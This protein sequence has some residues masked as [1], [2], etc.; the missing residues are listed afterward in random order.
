MDDLPD[1]AL[2]SF[3]EP[4][5]DEEVSPAFLAVSTLFA[6][7]TV[8]FTIKSWCGGAKADP[9][10][11]KPKRDPAC[12]LAVYPD[13]S[14]RK[15]EKQWKQQLS[16]EV[17]LSLRKAEADMPNLTAEEGG[18]EHF[19]EDGIFRCA[20]CGTPVYDNDARF[21][22]GCGWPC[23]YTCLPRA[24]RERRDVDGSRWEL[25]CNACEGHLGHIFRG[26]KW[27]HPPPAERH[28]INGRSLVFEAAPE[29]RGGGDDLDTID[30]EAA[31]VVEEGAP[32]K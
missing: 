17:F 1:D 29:Q 27:D 32:S 25:V 16:E 21:D 23:F 18:I 10:K 19:V 4:S 7:L 13:S 11:P 6:L 31:E 28:C 3:S 5:A 15:S 9:P 14:K 30:D 22:A 24:V 8:A 2:P 26:E 12:A 20:G